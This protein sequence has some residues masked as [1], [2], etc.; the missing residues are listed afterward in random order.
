MAKKDDTLLIGAALV[1]GGVL[2]L[3]YRKQQTIV[4]TARS[5]IG[6]RYEL[7]GS[8]KSEIDCSGLTMRAYQA[9]GIVLPHKAS[10]QR[11]MGHE[12]PESQISAGDIVYWNSGGG[13]HDHVGIYAGAGKV[14]HASSVYGR[15]VEDTL[16]QWKA[17]G[18]LDGIRR[19]L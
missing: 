10:T 9:A 14:V 7:G 13:P 2:F 6:T 1:V 5:Y 19:I 8:S 17:K 12:I 16:A 15:A 11:T 18:W 3:G 4:R